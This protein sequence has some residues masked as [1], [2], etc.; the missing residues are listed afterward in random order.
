M[1][2]SKH[3]ESDETMIDTIP[4]LDSSAV[5]QEQLAA[6][7]V[8]LQ[9]TMAH[10]ELSMEQLDLVITKQDRHI[11]TLQRQ[12]QMVYQQVENQQSEGGI[13]PFDVMADRPPH[14]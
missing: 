1:K 9:M 4:F 8:D 3:H 11:Q 7:I 10:L 13:A 14:Y 5:T 12:L 2:K 6:Q